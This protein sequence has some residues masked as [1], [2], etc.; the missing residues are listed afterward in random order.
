[1]ESRQSKNPK[2]AVICEICGENRNLPAMARLRANAD[3]GAFSRDSESAARKF[4][5]TEPDRRRKAGKVF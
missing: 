4:R 2:S 3:A 1:M 5:E